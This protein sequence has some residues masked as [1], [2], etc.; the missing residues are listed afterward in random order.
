MSQYRYSSLQ[1]AYN[2]QR[3][4]KYQY[5]DKIPTNEPLNGDLYFGTCM[6]SSIRAILEGE[7]GVDVFNTMWELEDEN[8]TKFG[9]YGYDDLKSQAEILLERFARLHSKFFT[10]GVH[11]R[12]IEFELTATETISGTPDF[13]GLYKGI[14]S[15][16]DFKTAGY[17][18]PKEKILVNQQMPLYSYGLRKL[19]VFDAKQYVYIVLIKGKEPSI[20]VLTHPIDGAVEKACILNVLAVCTQ[21]SNKHGDEDFV[22]NPNSCIQ[23]DGTKCPYWTK[24][25]GEQK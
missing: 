15:I 6:H 14:P 21:L 12:K 24:C 17:R 10:D 7:D 23:Y 22:Q 11:E 19:G 13:Y 5:I 1:T 9:R 4:F 25:H 8:K 18:Y 20:Q 2:C 3:K 16:V